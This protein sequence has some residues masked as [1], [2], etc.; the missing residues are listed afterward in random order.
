MIIP[1][2]CFTCNNVVG[3]KWNKYLELLHEKNIGDSDNILNINEDIQSVDD[4]SNNKDIFVK[5]NIKRYCCK[6][7][8]LGHVDILHKL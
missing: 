7:H 5:L 2:R 3:S 8:L 6:R 1:I 4:I